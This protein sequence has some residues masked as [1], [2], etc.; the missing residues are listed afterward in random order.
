MQSQNKF[1]EDL[2]KVL[3]GAAGTVAGMAREAQ[4]STRERAREWMGGA[5]GVSREEF[6]VLK[7]RLAAANAAIDAL[8]A[9]L[10]GIDARTASAASTASPAP[11]AKKSPAKG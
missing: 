7:D 6:E 9:R 4:E 3:N 2:A 1:F 10:D 5:D 8:R 11:K